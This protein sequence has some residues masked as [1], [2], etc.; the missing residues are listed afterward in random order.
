MQIDWKKQS[1]PANN[2]C[3]CNEKQWSRFAMN[4]ASKVL[5]FSFHTS[6]CSLFKHCA[7]FVVCHVRFSM[8]FIVCV[9]LRWMSWRSM[10]VFIW[11]CSMNGLLKRQIFLSNVCKF[12]LSVHCFP[13]RLIESFLCD[14]RSCDGHF[15]SFWSM[16]RLFRLGSRCFSSATPAVKATNPWKVGLGVGLG[17]VTI[18]LDQVGNVVRHSPI[19]DSFEYRIPI[20]LSKLQRKHWRRTKTLLWMHNTRKLKGRFVSAPSSLQECASEASC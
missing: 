8:H 7:E 16:H 13:F 6:N 11:L 3:T 14:R 9:G 15:S 17:L 10:F 1:N 20:G 4:R 2:P 12:A 19:C 5:V 18:L